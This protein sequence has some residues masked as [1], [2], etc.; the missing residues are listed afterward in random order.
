MATFLAADMTATRLTGTQ[1]LR[2]KDEQ[3]ARQACITTVTRGTGKEKI[4]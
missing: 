2:W 1:T 3:M 4:R